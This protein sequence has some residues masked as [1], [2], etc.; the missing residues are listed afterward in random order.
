MLTAS[1]HP[2]SDSIAGLSGTLIDQADI[3]V[4]NLTNIMTTIKDVTPEDQSVDLGSLQVWW[5]SLGRSRS[6][7]C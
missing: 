5:F 3:F 6:T 4:K 1:G 7:W 2:V